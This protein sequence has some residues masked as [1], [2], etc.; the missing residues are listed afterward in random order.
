MAIVQNNK[1]DSIEAK[2]KVLTFIVMPTE[3]A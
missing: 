3:K 2:I 1:I